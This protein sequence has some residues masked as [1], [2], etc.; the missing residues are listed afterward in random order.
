MWMLVM[1]ILFMFHYG[2]NF[3]VYFSPQILISKLCLE[4][5]MLLKTRD[6]VGNENSSST[7][8]FVQSVWLHSKKLLEMKRIIIIF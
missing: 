1:P 6:M 7:T 5:F 2:L 4:K 8:F 3:V